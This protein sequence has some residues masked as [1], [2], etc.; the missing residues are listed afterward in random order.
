IPTLQAELLAGFKEQSVDLQALRLNIE[1][2][3]SLSLNG[4]LQWG[5]ELAA[6]AQLQLQDL[7][8][9][10][11]GREAPHAL[12]GALGLQLRGTPSPGVAEAGTIRLDA[13]NLRGRWRDQPLQLMAKSVL[14]DGL[15]LSADDLRLDHADGK[16]RFDGQAGTSTQ[17]QW[18]GRLRANLPSLRHLADDLR[19]R[20]EL[21]L[22]L[23]G[24]LR[25]P[26]LAIKGRLQGLETL[27]LSL[28]V[29]DI[30]GRLSLRGAQ[31]SDLR[32]QLQHL[33]VSGQAV[34]QAQLQ[35]SGP[36]NALQGSL[37][38][39]HAE[40]QLTSRWMA[41]LRDWQSLLFELQSLD[42][43]LE[44]LGQWQLQ[45]S[46]PIRVQGGNWQAAEHCL[47]SQQSALCLEGQ[48][49]NGDLRAALRLQEFPLRRL[50]QAG[51][52]PVPGLRV[53]GKL[54]TQVDLR[55]KAGQLRVDASLSTTSIQFSGLQD[56]ERLTLLEL[57]PGQGLL[58]WDAAGLK[59]ELNLPGSEGGGLQ[60][61]LVA[62]GK[63]TIQKGSALLALDSLEILS[64]LHPEVVRATGRLRAQAQLSGSLQSPLALLDLALNEGQ[65]HLN[66]PG[67][68]LQQVELGLKGSLEALRL[69]GSLRSGEGQL[70]LQGDL[71]PAASAFALQIQGQ[72]VD[73]IDSEL[74]L[75]RISPD[76]QL[77]LA[78]GRLDVNGE[79]GIPYADI[80]PEELPE[81]GEAYVAPS[82]DEV[83]LGQEPVLKEAPVQVAS[84]LRLR[85]GK[86]V[87]VDG[88]GLKT[89]V[90]GEVQL[91][92]DPGR[93]PTANGELILV[94]GSYKAYG[95]DLTIERGRVIFSGGPIDAPGIDLRAYRKPRPDI[96][97]GI[98]A[99]GPLLKPRITLWS[100]PDMEQTEQ[101]SWLVLGRS[102]QAST[103]D[104]DQAALQNATLALGL[105]GSDFLAKQ[106]QGRLGLDELSIGTRPGED[107]SQAALV[108]GKYLN[109]RLYVSYGIGLFE[110]IYSFRLRY[111]I[112][113]KWTL[114]TESGV[115]SGGDIVYTIER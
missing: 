25:T 65:I 90:E 14:W 31:N 56:G 18:N 108:L 64:L 50:L 105:K 5:P 66:T 33:Q 28:R 92:L 80:H 47:R 20:A 81:A 84:R 95:Q 83:I 21:D 114:Q 63:G 30:Q 2:S 15:L 70:R 68:Q 27:D 87:R 42:L 51:D 7:D 62:D 54:S 98:R 9:R 82:A 40:G 78:N 67:I 106:V 94:D 22:Q 69:E 11:F 52:S 44:R 10:R 111:E 99:R 48:G 46:G 107:S 17:G 93:N 100:N 32:V 41:D 23:R 77:R 8:L 29:A 73:L 13:L 76:L 113:S 26:D 3:G 97:V 19:G 61:Q 55:Q 71:Q 89:G 1:Q 57:D 79:I 43:Q 34:P 37:Q 60:G 101:L 6:D 59:A 75:V 53:R 4:E 96:T 112:S 12:H 35:I 88:Y 103:S 86:E 109:P 91:R 38:A 24:A 49:Q 58:R 74:A 39:E 36:R 110:P 45:E 72:A 85:L 115:E 16:L 102:S 104:E